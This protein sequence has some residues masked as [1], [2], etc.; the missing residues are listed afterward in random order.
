MTEETTNT[1]VNNGAT[2]TQTTD[3]FVPAWKI[4]ADEYKK[5]A[6]ADEQVVYESDQYFDCLPSLRSKDAPVTY[7]FTTEEPVGFIAPKMDWTPGRRHW[8]ETAS[9]QQ[10]KDIE[11][12]KTQVATLKKVDQTASQDNQK[13]AQQV[14]DMSEKTEKYEKQNSQQ[15]GQLLTMVSTLIAKSG[16]APATNANQTTN[17]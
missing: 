11:T 17:N 14:N 3:T 6:S 12:L 2:E 13:I 10:G 1:G 8:I 7:P 15:L 4:K 5:K 9:I 16:T